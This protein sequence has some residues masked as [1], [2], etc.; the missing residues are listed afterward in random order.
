MSAAACDGCC[1]APIRHAPPSPSA[2]V[3]ATFACPRAAGD[4]SD[5]RRPLCVMHARAQ[6]PL[7]RTRRPLACLPLPSASAAAGRLPLAA[8]ALSRNGHVRSVPGRT[9]FCRAV[10]DPPSAPLS[11]CLTIA[12]LLSHSAAPCVLSSQSA[13]LC[14]LPPPSHRT[15]SLCSSHA[16][17]PSLLRALFA[18]LTALLSLSLSLSLSLCPSH[19]AALSLARRPRAAR[20]AHLVAQRQQPR[21]PRCR[22]RGHVILQR[23]GRDRSNG[24]SGDGDGRRGGAGGGAARRRPPK[25][26]RGAVRS[27]RARL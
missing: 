4:L 13:A 8:F 1:C 7:H 19:S 27:R 9:R 22:C 14:A 17:A 25:D 3:S 20:A 11:F 2:S 6:R 10:C 21:L 26:A 24:G 15:F 5:A 12:T 16:A 23:N 18:L